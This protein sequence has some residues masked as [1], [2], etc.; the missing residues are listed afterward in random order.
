MSKKYGRTYTIEELR[1]PVSPADA[2]AQRLGQTNKH[3]R[4]MQ[5]NLKTWLDNEQGRR[6][7]LAAHLGVTLGR[8]TQIADDGV[9]TKYMLKV[10]DF[11]GGTVTLE[12]M[13]EA[14]AQ[15]YADQSRRTAVS[16]TARGRIFTLEDLRL[17]ELS[18][19]AAAQRL[20]RTNKHQVDKGAG[21]VVVSHEVEF[22]ADSAQTVVITARVRMVGGQGH[23]NGVAD[24]D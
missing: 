8:V 12:S 17:P 6:T 24:V 23:A 16:A 22:V 18:A 5:T 20:G 7:A 9:P 10:R 14:R 19:Q 11:T 3:H 4:A 2:A 15:R 13:V 1:Q 21:A